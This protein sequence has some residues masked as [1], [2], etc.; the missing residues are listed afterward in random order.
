MRW[1]VLVAAI[2]LASPAAARPPREHADFWREVIEPNN[3]EV[4]ALLDKANRVMKA[5]DDALAADQDFAVDQRMRFYRDAYNLLRYARKLSPESVEVLA[6]LGRAADEIGKT[7]EAIEALETCVRVAGPDKAGPAVTGRLGAIYLRLEKYDAAVR[8]LR[9]AQGALTPDSA[10]ALVH[11]ANALAARGETTAAI[12]TLS[13][14]IP[15]QS[16]GPF[17][18]PLALVGFGLAVVYDRDEQR[19]AAFD[20]LDH[21]QSATQAEYGKNVQAELARMRFAPAADRHYY[22]AL[23]YES[24]NHYVEAR[25]EWALYAASGDLP[26]RGRALDHI[27][28][29]D[30]GRRAGPPRPLAPGTVAPPVLHRKIPRP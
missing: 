26:W 12:D 27:A 18:G 10:P 17:E 3:V 21:M 29:I 28:A 1:Q 13:N 16:A 11:L 8:W 4:A 23:L 15:V 20:V 30:G 7:A 24:L 25:A 22:Q 19:S 2:L 6:K 9:Y 5:P 14:V